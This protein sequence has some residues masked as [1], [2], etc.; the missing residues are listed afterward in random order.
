M[1]SVTALKRIVQERL[2]HGENSM[3]SKT[4]E[5]STA[6][7]CECARRGDALALKALDQMTDCLAIGITN[8]VNLMDIN[9]VLLSGGIVEIYPEMC[10]QISEKVEIRRNSYFRDWRVAIKPLQIGADA[11]MIGAATMLLKQIVD[12]GGNLK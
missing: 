5:P 4:A 6:Q 7:I 8:L 1:A 12:G 10:A 2:R 11:A 3:L 9:L